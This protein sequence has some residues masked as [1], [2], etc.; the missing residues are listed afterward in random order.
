[1]WAPGEKGKAE[2]GEERCH[3]E[4]GKPE[5]WTSR[6]SNAK[7]AAKQ[8]LCQ[9]VLPE[10]GRNDG[11]VRLPFLSGKFSLHP[12]CYELTG[13]CLIAFTSATR[14]VD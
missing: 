3:E 1:M 11:L 13:I 6:I 8:G 7:L 9:H 4:D 5:A 2:K 10:S 14:L 12:V